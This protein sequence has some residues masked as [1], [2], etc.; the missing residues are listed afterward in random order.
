MVPVFQH[1]KKALTLV[2]LLSLLVAGCNFQ[3]EKQRVSEWPNAVFY[4]I[5]VRAFYDS[6]GDGIGD[7]KGVIAKLDYLQ[8]LGVEGIWLMPINPSPSYHK[9]DVINYYDIDPE[10]GTLEDMKI[11]VAEAKKRDI[12]IIIDLVVNHTSNQNPWFQ[13]AIKDE[14]SPYR[15][16]YI[17]AD[18]KTNLLERGDWNQQLWYGLG[19]NKYY[20]TFWEGMP[21]LNYDNPDVRAEIIKIGKFWLQEVGVEGFRL[22]AAKYIYPD[23]E[24]EKNYAWWKEFRK[25]MQTVKE[26]VFLVG[27]VWDTATVTAPYLQ[28]DGLNSTFNFDL[29]ERIVRAV[30]QGK[31]TGIV[32]GLKRMREYFKK[33]DENYVDSIFLTNHDQ[34]RV[35]SLFKG[36]VNKARMAAAILLTLPGSP[37]LYYGEEIGMQG[38]KP[39]EYIREPFVWST[40]KKEGESRWIVSKYNR[41]REKIALETQIE[42]ENS[43][44]QYYKKLIQVRRSSDILVLGEIERSKVNE[45]GIVAFKRVLGNQSLLVLHNLSGVTK[46]FSLPEDESVYK[47]KFFTSDKGSAD[48]LNRIVEMQPYS[49]L[50]LAQ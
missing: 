10:Y 35:M 33:M 43:L 18:E 13:E 27:E 17:W 29:A 7:L 9:Y 50:I 14:N 30:Q 45:I 31:D 3:Q 23:Q 28:D 32:S 24:K 19:K 21:D 41:E 44:Y 2:I 12:K 11:L 34:N 38:M 40:D 6:N 25:A 8:E 42:E 39:D 36:D 4:E 37:F 26:D 47:K 15:D 1:G 16:W 49:T 48:K 46:T 5:F 20:S 22:D